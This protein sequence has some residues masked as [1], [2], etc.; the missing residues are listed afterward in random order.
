MLKSCVA[1]PLTPSGILE[2]FRPAL[3]TRFYMVV[4]C[5]LCAVLA[6]F[7]MLFLYEFEI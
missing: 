1:V 6:K 7:V 4:Q 3:F 5:A 2:T